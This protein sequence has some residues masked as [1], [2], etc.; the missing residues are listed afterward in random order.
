VR[1]A[2]ETPFNYVF[3]A[4]WAWAANDAHQ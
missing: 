2:T 1:V 3:E 4:R